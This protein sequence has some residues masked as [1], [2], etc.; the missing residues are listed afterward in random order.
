VEVPIDTPKLIQ[1]SANKE[2]RKYITDIFEKRSN[3]R[4]SKLS[5]VT[6][7]PKEPEDSVDFFFKVWR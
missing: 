7:T 2:K 6:S 1:N 4:I 3:E 5:A